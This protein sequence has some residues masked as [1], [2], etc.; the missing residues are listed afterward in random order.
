MWKFLLAVFVLITVLI[1]LEELIST[2]PRR[3]RRCKLRARAALSMG[4]WCQQYMTQYKQPAWVGWEVARCFSTAWKCAAGQISPSDRISLSPE[5]IFRF[6]PV[7]K[8][9]PDLD[10]IDSMLRALLG[11]N[12]FDQ[13]SS[14]K[15]DTVGDLIASLEPYSDEIG[16]RRELWN[17]EV[18][19]GTGPNIKRPIGRNDD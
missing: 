3:R 15:L 13:I 4:S 8:F 7:D 6:I 9:D 10:L 18:K 2:R 1:G 5:E 14:K 11:D 12:I 17:R 16:K 19:S